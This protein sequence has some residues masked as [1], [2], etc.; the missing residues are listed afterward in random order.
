MTIKKSATYKAAIRLGVLSMFAT[1][2]LC[3]CANPLAPQGGPRDSI[4]P[5]I[6]KA[7]P[8]FGATNFKGNRILIEFD[9]YVQLKEQQKEIFTSPFMGKKPAVA[10]RGKGIQIDLKESLDSNRTYV[11]NFGRSVVDNNESNPLTGLKYV[12]STGDKIDS[13][14]MSGQTVDALTKDTVGNV[15]LLFFDAKLDSIP[16]YDST[17]LKNSAMHVARSYPNGIFIAENLK[18]I[19]YRVYAMEDKNGTLKYEPG[20]DRIAFLEGSF[21]PA[22]MEPFDMW[23]DSTRMYTQADP[24]LS[25]QLFTEDHSKQQTHTGA[26]RPTANRVNLFFTAPNPQI[27]TLTFEGIDPANIITEYMNP[28]RDSIALWF[29]DPIENLPDT[30]KGR[31]VY[32]KH[33]S[34]G[35]LFS[36]TQELKLGW[37]KIEQKERRSSAK[38]TVAAPNPFKV[39]GGPGTSINP[40]KGFKFTFDYPLS[41][42]DSSAIMLEMATSDSTWV[43]SKFSIK[44]DSLHIRDWIFTAPW[45]HGGKYRLLIP[46]KTLENINLEYNDS[47]N[48]PFTVDSPDKFASLVLNINGKTPDSEYIIQVM[49]GNK[50]IEKEVAHLKT[51][52]YTLNFITPGITKIKVIED[53]NAN[54]KW[55]T[56]SLTNRRQP[57][58]VELFVDESGVEEITTKVNWELIFDLYMDEIFSPVTMEKLKEKIARNEAVREKK[59]AEDRAKRAKEK[60]T[61]SSGMGIG[62]AV[63]GMSGGVG[64]MTT[65]M[66]GSSRR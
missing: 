10:L 9:E 42:V 49:T 59:M 41:K 22:E 35:V 60:P 20:V 5:R 56:G 65:G 11:I 17:V 14:I 13:M 53:L 8:E 19:P 52:R 47:I 64:G 36:Q 51:G 7:T 25:M 18:P 55:D 24:Q 37:R 30:I 27:D 29:K 54:G 45:E 6:I 62:S 26:A 40:E 4:P 50:T 57:E 21:N 2:F 34:L 31:M 28:K 23:Y 58:R 39:T 63:G 66:G 43:K 15:F 12:F 44:Q 38:D 48:K 61:Q 3:R 32:K 33:D 46:E 16:Q 1:A